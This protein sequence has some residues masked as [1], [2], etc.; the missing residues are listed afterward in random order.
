MSIKNF[1]SKFE[2]VQIKPTDMPSIVFEKDN[3]YYTDIS[4][5]EEVDSALIKAYNITVIK[6][7]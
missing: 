6:F 4:S 3:K 7:H 2:E 1:R 5:S